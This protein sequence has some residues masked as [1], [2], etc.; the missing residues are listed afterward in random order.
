[1]KQTL[2]EPID[3]SALAMP[4]SVSSP[5]A[6]APMLRHLWPRLWLRLA[7]CGRLG[8]FA[9]RMAAI[10]MPPYYGRHGLACLGRHGFIEPSAVLFHQSLEMTGHVYIGN[11]CT[12]YQCENGGAIS[13]ADQVVVGDDCILQTG[14]GGSI[15]ISAGTHIQPKC[16]FSS[17]LAPIIIGRD[18]QI[19]PMCAFYS[20]N[21]GIV[22]GQRIAAQPLCSRGG[23]VIG[24]DVWFGVGAKVTAGVT[25]GSGAV[26]AAGA[27][28][29]KDVPSNAIMGGV[30]A[31]TLGFRT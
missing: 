11:R 3:P 2:I 9:C 24:D 18:V 8:R 6:A 10:G 29:T 28:V 21:H 4:C 12:V 5:P 17:F 20:Y 15:T 23:I 26:I 7:G 19:A 14:Q 30:P 16:V 25:I 31:K 27:V 13:L 1:M 22:A